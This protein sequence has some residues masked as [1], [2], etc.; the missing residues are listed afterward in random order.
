MIFT[1]EYEILIRIIL[2]K[3][4]TD[5]VDSQLHGSLGLFRNLLI[6]LQFIHVGVGT[7]QTQSAVLTLHDLACYAD[8]FVSGAIY[9]PESTGHL[10]GIHPIKEH[11]LR[12]FVGFQIIF[13]Y[14]IVHVLA[15]VLFKDFLSGLHHRIKGVIDVNLG[16]GTLCQFKAT[17][18]CGNRI[19]DAGIFLLLLYHH[20]VQRLTVPIVSNQKENDDKSNGG[21]EKEGGD[22]ADILFYISFLFIDELYV[23][24]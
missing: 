11:T 2:E 20:G 19:D 17:D 5:V 23:L 13:V 9:Q 16:Q 14:R 10:E 4:H 24:G 3:Q 8:P 12:L 15:K 22:D 6:M 1:K 18:T 7:V 21:K